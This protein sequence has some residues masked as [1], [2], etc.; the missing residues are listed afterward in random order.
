M[1]ALV[2]RAL[3][4]PPRLRTRASSGRSGT[5]ACGSR[6]SLP[7]AERSAAVGSRTAG[8][9]V[10]GHAAARATPDHPAPGDSGPSSAGSR[11]PDTP[12][13]RSSRVHLE[14]R[15]AP[16]PSAGVSHFFDSIS[17]SAALSS[18]ASASSF[19]SLRVLRPGAAS[20]ASPRIRPYHRI[21]SSSCRR[22]PR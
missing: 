6:R 18:I 3:L 4:R 13:A 12:A 10:P 7:G 2:P 17:F 11:S 5:A 16:P 1:G 20:A 21:C 8:V 15:D 9:P 19:F 14:M 22:S